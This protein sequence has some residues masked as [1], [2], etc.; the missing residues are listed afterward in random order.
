MT[1]KLNPLLSFSL[2]LF[3]LIKKGESV[4]EE[5]FYC[6]LENLIHNYWY[7]QPRINR[8]STDNYKIILQ[9]FLI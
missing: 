6:Q 3:C 2:L 4:S 5:K 7:C 8:T 1:P 9:D